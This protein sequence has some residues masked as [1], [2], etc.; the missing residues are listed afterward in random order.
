MDKYDEVL[1]SGSLAFEKMDRGQ[2]YLDQMIV[3]STQARGDS[4]RVAIRIRMKSAESVDLY[5]GDFCN[6]VLL[7][8]GKYCLCKV[9][10]ELG[11]LLTRPT[12]SPTLYCFI[13][14][15]VT[16]DKRVIGTIQDGLILFPAGSFTAAA[17]PEGE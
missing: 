13:P 5:K 4:Y 8:N 2:R 10:Q 7:P 12:K 17:K 16:T 9:R 15:I 11:F 3:V 1:A 14:H 6:L